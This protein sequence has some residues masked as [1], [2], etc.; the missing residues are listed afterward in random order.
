MSKTQTAFHG[1]DLEKIQEIY[2]VRKEDV[3]NFAANV[4]PFGISSSLKDELAS[5]LDV[6]S[7][8]PD[9]D[10]TLLRKS[11]GEYC[12]AN[13]EHIVVG[14]G[15]TELISI[16]AQFL[17]PQSALILSPTYSEYSREVGLAGGQV[18]YFE[19]KETDDFS[20][21]MDALFDEMNKKYDM[22]VICNP[23]NP[24]SGALHHAQLRT[25]FEYAKKVGTFIV[26]DETYVEF[27]RDYKDITAVTLT[28]EYSNFIVLRGVS[29]FFA[30]PGLRLGYAV[31]SNQELL[32][33]IRKKQNPWTV[34]SLAEQAGILMFKD[35]EYIKRTQELMWQEQ[36]RMYEIFAASK[37]YK[38][39]K[40]NANFI[41]LK[42]L[43]PDLDAS[44]LFDRCI[45]QGLMIRNCSSFPYLNE[46]FIRFCFMKPEDN[47]RL[48]EVLLKFI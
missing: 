24:T 35:T 28:E 23:N 37:D 6:I 4:N 47:D 20:L 3:V 34:N 13:P 1:S 2:G 18:C 29:K 26:I 19:L 33:T 42:I 44:T 46:K 5:N 31:T 27:A 17:E 25:I 36:D 32:D 38:P 15:S 10:Y 41:L 22:L 39:Y 7:S 16:M 40:A 48:V 43:N 8:Y 9:R 11:I 12:N 21:D 30:A 14:N 45:R